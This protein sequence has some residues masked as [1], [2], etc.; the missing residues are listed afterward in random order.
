MNAHPPQDVI[1]Q[2]M[3]VMI[4]HLDPQATSYGAS[5]I[6]RRGRRS[7]V[8]IEFIKTAIKRLLATDDTPMTVRQV[9]YRLVSI[10]VI[11]KTEAEY[12]STVAFR[13]S[14]TRCYGN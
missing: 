1:D 13:I 4:D 5:P 7:K 12:K 3:D 11:E 10:G 2:I 6:K 9:F 8:E 14:A